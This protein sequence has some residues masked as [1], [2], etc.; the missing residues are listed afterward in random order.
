[1]HS[2]STEQLQ[3]TARWLGYV[4]TV[5]AAG[6]SFTFGWALGG[7]DTAAQVMLAVGFAALTVLV[8]IMLHFVEI[9]WKS[10]DK[11][12][13]VPITAFFVVCVVGEYMSHVGF[14]VGHRTENVEQAGLQ[15]TRYEDAR[16]KVEEAKRNLVMWTEQLQTLTTAN[17]WAATTKA[18]G[19]RTQVEAA[20]KAIELE[21]A[22]G[23]CK[24]RCQ[25][26]IKQKG[27]LEQRIATVELREDLTKRIEATKAL[28]DRYREQAA[29]TDKGHSVAFNQ[30]QMVAQLA[31]LN[32]APAAA[33]VAWAGYGIGAFV[34]LIF[35]FAAAF[36]NWIGNRDWASKMDAMAAKFTGHATPVAAPLV[37]AAQPTTNIVRETYVVDDEEA[38]RLKA[39]YEADRAAREKQAA[40]WAAKWGQA[41][42]LKAA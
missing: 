39:Q 22:R 4:F 21:E 2:D 23:G 16:E 5:L 20:Q 7:N 40:E 30:T 13:A 14:T 19:M 6:M 36:C 28:V 10:G 35:T 18:E 34:S 32:L 24:Q 3:R 1:M 38:K 27:E 11:W 41:L 25:I 17:A 9:A 12:V 26:L 29:T 33:Q 8:A 42:S 15:T 37:P 31:T